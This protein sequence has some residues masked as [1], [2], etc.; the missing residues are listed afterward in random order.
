MRINAVLNAD[1]GTLR[2][3]DLEA[4][5][6]EVVDLFAEAGHDLR[7]HCT[8]GHKLSEALASSFDDRE[9]GAVIAAGGDGTI[10]AAAAVAWRTGKPLGVIPAGTMNLFARSL[11]I[12]L[13]IR[14]AARALAH[15]TIDNCDIATANG[16]P[17]LHQFS[18]GFHPHMVRL[19]N[20]REYHSR[21][22]KIAAS[23]LAA[24]EA[25]R[26][27]PKFNVDIAID[28]NRTRE[29]LSSL[30]VS[31][32]P[33]GDGHLPYADD[34]TTGELGV[35][36]ARP[37]TVSA[38]AGML[39]DLVVGTWRANPDIVERLGKRVALSFGRVPRKAKAVIDGELIDLPETVEI[40]IHPGEL[41]ILRPVQDGE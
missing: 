3:T 8:P 15:H 33:Y 34:P 41:R 10:S 39:A 1:G 37:A 26:R 20:A 18:V 16:R 9:A 29:R 22:G 11:G 36:T 28:G 32:N 23:L 19:R 4:Y 5:C 30:A 24:L 17:Y 40:K 25:V 6:A 31:N 14:D 27:P 2:T 12:P 35:Y 13:E 38:N 7:C 21:L